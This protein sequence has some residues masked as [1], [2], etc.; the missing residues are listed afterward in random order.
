[1]V[2]KNLNVAFLA[3]VWYNFSKKW[4]NLFMVFRVPVFKVDLASYNEIYQY[5]VTGLKE[6]LDF[7][8]VTA[9]EAAKS[10][11]SSWTQPTA[12]P[13][14]VNWTDNRWFSIGNQS[15]LVV[16]IFKAA[17]SC[18]SS[19]LNAPKQAGKKLSPEEKQQKE[20]E[21]KNRTANLAAVAGTGTMVASGYTLG[22]LLPSLQRY[23]QTFLITK[24]LLSD[25]AAAT[26][27]PE[28]IKKPL[29]RFVQVQHEIDR[30]RYQKICNY[31]CAALGA[32]VGG[33]LMAFGGILRI[34]PI[35]KPGLCILISSVFAAAVVFGWHRQDGKRIV[36]CYKVIAGDG[37]THNGL[38][39]R[40]LSAIDETTSKAA[41]SPFYPEYHRPEFANAS[42]PEFGV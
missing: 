24:T 38:A 40:I 4:R 41:N 22:N 3:R 17:I 15:S 35:I 39:R 30:L 1:V 36:E 23:Y 37:E 34:H 13:I 14:I 8:R 21:Q 31:F 27:L 12:R 6:G 7:L 11:F 10:S 2:I 26:H 29:T 5:A 20:E 42:A 19:F 18:L 32:A 33:A 25:L 28:N 9:D 16:E